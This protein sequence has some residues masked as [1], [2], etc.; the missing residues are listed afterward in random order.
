MSIRKVFVHGVANRDHAEW[1]KAQK[2]R[3]ELF[4]SLVFGSGVQ[5]TNPYWGG[6]GA[7]SPSGEWR[8]LPDSDRSGADT[9][10]LLSVDNA[11]TVESVSLAVLAAQ[12]FADTLDAIFAEVF[13][14]HTRNDQTLPDEIVEFAMD[15]EVN[16]EVNSKP[17]WIDESLSDEEFLKRLEFAAKRQPILHL[18]Q[19]SSIAY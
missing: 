16:A 2:Q 8:S 13:D 14:E 17:G 11:P 12:N 3:D 19:S 4:K 7:N 5:I 9:V 18:L 6:L 1:R 15:A 10:E